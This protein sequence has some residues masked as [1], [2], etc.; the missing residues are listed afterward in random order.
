MPRKLFTLLAII[1]LVPSIANAG[2]VDDLEKVWAAVNAQK[3]GHAAMVLPGGKT[4]TI[5]HVAPD[6]WRIQRYNG[7]TMLVIGNSTYL[8]QN[9]KTKKLDM[10]AGAGPTVSNPFARAVGDDIK[11]SARD[12]GMQ[13]L[14]GQAVHVYSFTS[15]GI[16]T[17]LYVGAN[18]LPVQAV[19]QQAQGI[20]VT[21]TFSQWN[22]PMHIEP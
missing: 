12:L 9:G 2:P 1:Y 17:T 8:I 18:N 15:E 10:P 7:V 3:S 19:M 6:R 14:N 22:A 11:R 13:T 5:D 21:M 20:S 4:D 16:P